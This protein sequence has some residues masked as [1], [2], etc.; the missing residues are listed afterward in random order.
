[1]YY[2]TIFTFVNKN[3]KK[4]NFGR[5]N[6][7]GSYLNTQRHYR[8]CLG[9]KQGLLLMDYCP[10]IIFAQPAYALQGK[11][12]LDKSKVCFRRFQSSPSIQ[13]IGVADPTLRFD[14]LT[15]MWYYT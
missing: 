2:T 12:I 3:F 8:I 11:I 4:L 1:L 15:K 6:K 14:L 13:A 9:N 7:Q 5:N 10:K